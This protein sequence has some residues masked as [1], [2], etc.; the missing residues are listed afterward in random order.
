MSQAGVLKA[1][2]HMRT[3]IPSIPQ[4]LFAGLAVGSAVLTSQ[5][6]R[7]L[8]MQ[9]TAVDMSSVDQVL[10]DELTD[11]IGYFM[12]GVGDQLSRLLNKDVP[13]IDGNYSSSRGIPPSNAYYLTTYKLPNGEI[14]TDLSDGNSPDLSELTSNE[15]RDA[16]GE[17]L[18]PQIQ[19]SFPAGM[20]GTQKVE[21]VEA[22]RFGGVGPTAAFL[23]IITNPQVYQMNTIFVNDKGYKAALYFAGWDHVKNLDNGMEQWVKRDVARFDS[24]D[25]SIHNFEAEEFQKFIEGNFTQTDIDELEELLLDLLGN[26]RRESGRAITQEE[27]DTA[28]GMIRSLGIA[29][30]MRNSLL[31]TEAGNELAQDLLNYQETTLAIPSIGFLPRVEIL[32]V[33]GSGVEYKVAS[34]NLRFVAE[35]EHGRRILESLFV[36]LNYEYPLGGTSSYREGYRGLNEDHFQGAV[37]G[38]HDLTLASVRLAEGGGRSAFC[39]L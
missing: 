21:R 32:T 2:A 16:L 39:P 35:G 22:A 26:D 5:L 17:D 15:L 14:F 20:L 34:D 25:S 9:P 27:A 36:Q 19:V 37:Y 33:P 31:A 13:T 11:T 38:K 30:T 18:I 3:A 23:Q 8:R 28:V 1:K 7:Y 10:D 29:Q 4:F 6:G 12:L 24:G